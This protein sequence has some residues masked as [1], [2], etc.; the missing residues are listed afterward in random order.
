MLFC[1]SLNIQEA[2]KNQDCC[3]AYLK[4]FP[5]APTDMGK[6]AFM[7]FAKATLNSFQCETKS[8][9]LVPEDKF[10]VIVNSVLTI[11]LKL[12]VSLRKK[13]FFFSSLSVSIEWQHR[14]TN[15]LLYTRRLWKPKIRF[16]VKV[17]SLILLFLW[18]IFILVNLYFSYSFP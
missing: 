10:K 7:F 17:S 18:H 16:L 14:V 2:E 5:S 12:I 11:Y 1:I 13:V 3:C 6:I 9:N 15:S 8:N 4:C